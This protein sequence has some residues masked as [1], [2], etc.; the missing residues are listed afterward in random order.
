MRIRCPYERAEK[1]YPIYYLT[2][3]SQYSHFKDFNVMKIAIS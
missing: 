1:V 2:G 3:L